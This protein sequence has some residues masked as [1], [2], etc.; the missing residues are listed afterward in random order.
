MHDIMFL[1]C[2]QI[3]LDTTTRVSL[4]ANNIPKYMP[5]W[6]PGGL[7]SRGVAFIANATPYHNGI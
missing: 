1:F 2:W 5:V 7:H 3:S 6:D 4:N